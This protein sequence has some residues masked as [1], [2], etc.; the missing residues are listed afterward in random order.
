MT[1]EKAYG[2]V[3][4]L[5]SLYNKS[6]TDEQLTV[7]LNEIKTLDEITAQKVIKDIK[8]NHLYS[9]YMPN[10]P[11]FLQLYKKIF[12]ENLV[13]EQK[14]DY[15]YVCANKGIE[16]IRETKIINGFKYIYDY[17]LHCDYC[18]KGEEEKISYKNLY[19]E[20]ISKYLN[21]DKLVRK[22]K[23][24]RKKQVEDKNKFKNESI[25]IRYES[26]MDIYHL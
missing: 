16:M 14:D 18:R 24:K 25:N 15:C 12:N 6:L 7:W 5:T 11:Q 20:P 22:N 26:L 2:I 19:T 13:T 23:E 3:L 8:R 21:V 9:N 17:F 4:N 1:A 10:L